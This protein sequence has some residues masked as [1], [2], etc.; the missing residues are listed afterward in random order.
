MINGLLLVFIGIVYLFAT[1]I[2]DA[3]DTFVAVR[4]TVINHCPYLTITPITHERETFSPW[5]LT[6]V[7]RKAVAL[8]L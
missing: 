8:A 4:L 5:S 1:I 2:L 7:A 3:E 6:E